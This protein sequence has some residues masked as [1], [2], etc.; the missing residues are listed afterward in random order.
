M[1]DIIVKPSQL[2]GRVTAPPSKS[3]VHRA[4]ICAALSKGVCR[5]APVALSDDIKAT[6]GCVRS[7]GAATEINGDVLTVNGTNIFKNKTASLDCK[8]SGSTLRFFVPVAAAGGIE[9]EFSGRGSLVSRPIGLFADILPKA[10]VD[11]ETSGTLPLKIKGKLKAGTFEVAGNISS[12]FITGLLFA[13]PLLDGDSKIVLTT[14]LQSVG[15]IDMTIA[16]LKKFGVNVETTDYGWFVK[17]NQK[18]ISRD[19][20]TDGD[21]SQAAFFLT[22]GAVS[23]DVTVDGIDINS[24]QGDKEIVNLLKRFGADVEVSDDSVRV[25]KSE[26]SKADIDASQI[27]D[28]VPILSVLA[29]CAKNNT[30]IHSAERLRIKESDRLKTTADMLKAVGGKVEE[31]SDGL[32]IFGTGGFKGGTVDGSND[33]RIVMSA[34]IAALACKDDVK[35]T[36]RESINKSFPNFFDEYK[37]LGGVFD[38]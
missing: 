18:Y 17:G 37:R 6:I 15:Y 27:P 2:Y 35:I 33:H 29:G 23:G 1:S 7:L 25:R 9:T 20:R 26:L 22:A 5:I 4:I 31:K 16:C 12:Q 36:D 30:V 21:W 32:E 24:T 28:L 10:G 34:A 38:V 3:D 14:P 11:C 19:Y 8:E 13:L